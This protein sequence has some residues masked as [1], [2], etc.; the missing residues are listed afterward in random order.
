MTYVLRKTSPCDCGADPLE[1]STRYSDIDENKIEDKLYAIFEEVYLKENCK[2]E[3]AELVSFVL[4][5]MLNNIVCDSY[6]GRDDVTYMLTYETS[7]GVD[8]SKKERY[9]D[10]ISVEEVIQT[11]INELRKNPPSFEDEED[12]ED[13]EESIGEDIET[14]N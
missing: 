7:D 9:R 6:Y 11:A 14:N 13:E 2:L 1:P 5:Q 3:F 12:E 4:P 10:W 8:T